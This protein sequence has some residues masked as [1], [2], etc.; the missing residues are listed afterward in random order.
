MP[1]QIRNKKAFFNYEILDKFEAG[2]SLLGAEVKSL[3][4]GRGSLVGAFVTVRDGQAYLKNFQIPKWEF[5][6]Q[7]I[8]PL[9]DRKLLLRK[10]EIKKIQ[11]KLDEKGHT[12]VP[13]RL[14]FS[15]GYAKLEIALA[16]GKQQHDKRQTIKERDEKRRLAVRLK[17]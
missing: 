1:P 13:L 5:A 14:Y 10:R 8:D 4:A 7:T 2:I 11:K 15:R 16:K 12:V 3:R 17:K 6:Q 9:R